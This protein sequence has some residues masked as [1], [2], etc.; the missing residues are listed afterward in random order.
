MK[1][2]LRVL[3]AVVNMNRGGA[4]TLLMNLYRNIDRSVI[5][6]DFLTCKE[7]SYDE[8]I[9][10]LGGA[11]Y[12]IPYVTDVGHFKY[13]KAL[14][15]F[16]SAQKQY[17]IVHAHMDKMSGFILRAAR[18]A[19]IP[20]R[21][22]HS[23]NTES[24]GSLV[25]KGYKWYAGNYI[26]FHASHY[27]ACS[28]KASNWLFGKKSDKAMIL[29][30]AIDSN[31]FTYSKEIES[32]IRQGLCIR[33]GAFVAGHVGRFCQQKNHLFLI[34]VFNE[35]TKIRPDAYL[36]LVGD[37]PLKGE[38]EEKV[39]VLGLENKIFFLGIREDVA[40]ILQSMDVLIFPS[41]HEGLPLTLIE[42]QGAGVPCLI[43]D[44][45]SKESDIGANLITYENLNRSKKVW[46]LRALLMVQDKET[47]SQFIQSSGYDITSTATQ[48]EAFYQEI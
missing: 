38:V 33:S 17:K 22:A 35:L 27:I 36:I 20:Y 6:F 48:L 10:S 31:R 28:R 40:N 30:N 19:G 7:G 25:T 14:D 2:P 26:S 32:Q 5:Q 41:F 23:H 21:L 47:K 45:I 37:G 24:E 4:E 46:A 11:I 29:K 9:R 34:D 42:A 3:H 13:I 39:K 1:K 12:R 8:E 18:K 16:F 43:S 15:D 44:V